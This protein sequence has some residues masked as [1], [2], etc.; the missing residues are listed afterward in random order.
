MRMAKAA[1]MSETA[2]RKRFKKEVGCSPLD[3]ITRRRIQKAKT[4]M[5]R[6]EKS[7]TGISPRKFQ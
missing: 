1:N 4:L 6:G 3:Y 7:I 5:A 2:F